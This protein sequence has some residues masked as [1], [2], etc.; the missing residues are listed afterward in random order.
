MC[1]IVG[2]IAKNPTQGFSW[3][4]KQLFTQLLYA[5]ALRGEDSTG[6]FGVN[7]YGNL[8]MHK[9][10]TPAAKFIG[11]KTYED[12][13]DRIYRDFVAVIGHNRAAT[14]GE[15]IDENAHPFIEDNIC[16]IHNGTL[17]SHK[18]LADVTVDSHAI[19][20]S[21]AEV[22]HKKTFPEINGAYAL[23]WYDA[24]Q[25]MLR[26]ARNS[27]RPLHL[28]ET[29][30]AFYIASE[31]KM[32]DW[33]VAR[34]LGTSNKIKYFD[35]GKIF[36]WDIDDLQKGFSLEDV[37]EKKAFLP[38]QNNFKG[39]ILDGEVKTGITTTEVS[40]DKFGYKVGDKV[41]FIHET[42]SVFNNTVTFRGKTFDTNSM[43]VS[44]T[45]NVS[46]LTASEL[47]L[48]LNDSEYLVG[49]Y[50]G[51]SRHKGTT[52]LLLNKVVNA[53][54]F[55]TCTGEIVT[56][57][58]I[59]DA[60]YCCHTCG[61]VIQPDEENGAFWAKIKNGKIKKLM[62]S[63]CVDNHQHL[64][65]KEK[66][67]ITNESSSYHTIQEADQPSAFANFLERTLGYKH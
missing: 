40:A 11:T 6:V 62:C 46:S 10:A 58:D 51:F 23:I 55:E 34:N 8:I 57:Q 22:G 61:T 56:E 3:K 53:E 39:T 14:R 24:A 67:W 33:V 64:S 41:I 59:A 30:S 42:N 31:M 27:E 48:L 37:P 15:K 17:T 45:C 19:C 38:I 21:F 54:I 44:A 66:P 50:V 43:E 7:K 18:H 36:S 2:M 1:G 16:L 49:E 28:I 20:K 13:E 12:F 65:N 29:D 5:D 4:D 26:I 63:V 47:S 60:G 9:A 52:K 32:L 35:V 25:K